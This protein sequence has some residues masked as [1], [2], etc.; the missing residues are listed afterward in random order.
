MGEDDRRGDGALPVQPAAAETVN[1]V[2]RRSSLVARRSSLVARRS[3]LVARRSSL[4]ARRS[5]LVARRSSL[6]GG[7]L[8]KPMPWDKTARGAEMRCNS[9]LWWTEMAA[10]KVP[11]RAVDQGMMRAPSS[12][13]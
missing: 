8:E 11:V 10:S 1:V 3:S 13:S 6:V 2:A 4:V 9:P 5:S 7:I 12:A